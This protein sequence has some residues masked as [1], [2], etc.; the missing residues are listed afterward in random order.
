MSGQSSLAEFGG[1]EDKVYDAPF[2]SHHHIHDVREVADE[3]DSVRIRLEF[4]VEVD[5]DRFEAGAYSEDNCWEYGDIPSES[6]V[7]FGVAQ[8]VRYHA[9]EVMRYYSDGSAGWADENP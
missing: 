7:G 2:A 8:E 4:V 3:G 6:E 5:G 1:G 9:Q